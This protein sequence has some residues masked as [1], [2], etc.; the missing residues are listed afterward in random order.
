[1]SSSFL[2]GEIL[3]QFERVRNLIHNFQLIK[4]KGRNLSRN[5]AKQPPPQLLNL[6]PR[7]NIEQPFNRVPAPLL[8]NLIHQAHILRLHNQ[9]QIDCTPHGQDYV[10]GCALLV[11]L[12]E[13]VDGLECC[14]QA[15]QQDW[16]LGGQVA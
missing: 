14:G 13:V 1:M 16:L 8:I 9:P 11:Q 5:K 15:L 10:L 3:V 4:R 7:N 12:D 6:Q 2:L